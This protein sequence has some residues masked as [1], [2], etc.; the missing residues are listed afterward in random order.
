MKQAIKSLEML[1]LFY[2]LSYLPY[3]MITRHLATVDQPGL[4]RPLTGL[5]ILPAMLLIAAMLTLGFSWYAGWFANVR[6]VPLGPLRIPFAS[7]QTFLL[8]LCT[9]VII[10]VVPLS[11]TLTGVSIPLIQLLMRGDIL[12]IAPLVDILCGRKVRWRSWVA[13]ALVGMGMVI[14]FIG[15]G[16]IR[17]PTEAIVVVVVY[18]A[19]Y[20]GRL[21]IMSRISKDGDPEKMKTVF[22]EEKIV[23]FPVALLALATIGVLASD[24]SQAGELKMGFLTMWSRPV[25]GWIAICG[26]MVFLTGIFASFILL[27]ARENSF[28]VPL[29]RA[30]SILAGVIGAVTLSWV[31]DAP[32]PS[33]GELAGA[34]FLVAAILV[35]TVSLRKPPKPGA[36]TEVAERGPAVGYPPREN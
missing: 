20:F 32:M 33:G 6:R 8:G 18:T 23:G 11:Y 22:L 36:L 3:I 21:M 29:E 31:F 5:E 19:A 35:L 2:F 12:I 16:S 1:T 17:L 27:D 13:L 15:R 34:G 7:R 28:C 10:T 9:A 26:V 30:A 25:I 14:A 4:A 24:G